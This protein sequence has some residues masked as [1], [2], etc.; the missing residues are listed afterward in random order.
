MM[1]PVFPSAP[2]GM[3][4]AS[5]VTT[6]LEPIFQTVPWLGVL[7]VGEKTMSSLRLLASEVTATGNAV[8]EETRA[9]AVKREVKSCIVEVALKKERETRQAKYGVV[10]REARM[11]RSGMGW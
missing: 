5:H 10:E 9:R 1:V 8:T 6:C 2:C 4:D 11:K 7:M 3:L